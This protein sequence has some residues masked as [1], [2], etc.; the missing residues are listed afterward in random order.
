MYPGA[1]LIV[2]DLVSLGNE[3]MITWYSDTASNRKSNELDWIGLYH[4]GACSEE[5]PESRTI[6]AAEINVAKP[7]L[8]HQCFIAR[9][10]V[11]RG[12]AN[13]IVR[14]KYLG[15]SQYNQRFL[16]ESDDSNMGYKSAG[17]YEA[18][19]FYGDSLDANGYKCGLQPGTLQPGFFC[20]LRPKAISTSISVT[21]SG[22][23]GSME[24]TTAHLV[25][26]PFHNRLQD[27]IWQ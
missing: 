5:R 24:A 26:D 19:Y 8:L 12:F 10:Y 14:F 1:K 21:K 27:A 7:D 6:P 18:R 13:G 9:V 4:K 17:E 20:A 3:I 22:Q 23:A 16:S 11:G 2:P 25:S 15:L